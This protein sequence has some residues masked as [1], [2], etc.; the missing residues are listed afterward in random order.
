M[1]FCIG[2]EM[3]VHIIFQKTISS[4]N[5]SFSLKNLDLSIQ[6]F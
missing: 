6:V 1:A 2:L 4:I 5:L 3:V